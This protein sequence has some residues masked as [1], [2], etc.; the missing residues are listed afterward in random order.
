[1]KIAVVT[2]LV[3]LGAYAQET[4]AQQTLQA[5]AREHAVDIEV[6]GSL[7]TT[8]KTEPTQK[9]PYFFPV[10]GPSSLNSVTTESSEPY[11]H[12][13][14]LFLACDHVNGGNYWQEGLDR[15]QIV[16]QG[17]TVS[18]NGPEAV[19]FTDRCLW[20]KPGEPAIIE[21]ARTFTVTAPSA[22]ERMI[23]A[24]FSL[25]PLVDVHIATTNHS[26]FAA[27]MAPDLSVTGGGILVNANGDMGEG[28][29][30][31]VA[32]PWC[33]YYGT[34][35]DITEGL[36]IFQHPANRWY[37]SQWFTRAYGFFSPT[38]MNWLGDAGLDLPKGETLTLRYRVLVHTGTT[39]D[40]GIAK[41]FENYAATAKP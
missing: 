16:S 11:P 4:P 10:N 8:Y 20:Q 12:H 25:T 19:V 29:T 13:H 23:D 18:T 6:G 37:P 38:P 40:A 21:D 36:A 27:R 9:Y 33:D 3:C 35:N 28:K 2:L 22:T 15:G 5:A 26:L 17:L 39:D 31:G 32:A 7:F 14:S 1:M 24:E 41:A 30:F 34:R